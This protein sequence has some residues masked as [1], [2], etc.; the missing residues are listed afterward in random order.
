MS[1]TATG[2]GSWKSPITSES[3][4]K[5]TVGL[6][7]I[8]CEGTDRYWIE[9]R[10]SEEGRSVIVRCNAQGIVA[11]VTPPGFNAR[12]R[13]HEYGGGDYVVHQGTVF[14][15]NFSDQRLYRQEP[16]ATPEPITPEGTAPGA[17]ATGNLRYA[18]AVVD[19]GRN[20]LIC[21][22]E[23]HSDPQREAVNTLV[24]IGFDGEDGAGLLLVSGN[25]FY[26]SPRASPDGSRLAWLSWNHPHMPWD[27]TEL[28]VADFGSDGA[29]TN[30]RRVA[31]GNDESIF[32][33]EWSPDGVLYFV[34]DRS[35]WWNI[36]R[37]AGNGSIELV[38]GKDA[39]F[40]S[41]QWVFGMS[42]Y[43]FVS[44]TRIVCTYAE[45]GIWR[46]GLI[47]TASRVLEKIETPYSDISS[48]RVTGERTVFR[49]GSPNDVAAVV[50]LDLATRETTVLRRSNNV[51]VDPGYVSIPQPIEFPT[52]AGLTAH[53]FFYAPHNQD[54]TAPPN[55]LPLLLVK[56]HG[57]PTSAAVTTLGFNL[58][59]W[60]SRGIAVLDVNYGGSSG[61]GREYRRRLRGQWGI[62]DVDDCMNGA[63]HLVRDGKADPARLMI[64]GG[65][66]GG[67]TT[68]C[69]LTFRD[70]F[71]AGASHFGVSDAEALAKETHKFESRY[72][73]GLIG[74]YPERRDLYF[75]RSP[76][77]FTDQLSCPV[78]F[79][80]G[81]EDKIVPPSQ[82]E[83]MVEALRKKGIPVA[84]VAFAGEQHGFRRAANIRR[85]QDGE[86]YFY[87]RVFGFDLAEALEPVEIYNLDHPQPG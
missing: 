19:R 22:R 56:S 87:S 6:G 14:F 27:E 65:S 9:M 69:A 76:I 52:T 28:W 5:E 71:N 11:D 73:D 15:S 57:G 29:I 37:E 51:A 63:L 50:E 17:S 86:L 36:Y 32:Q 59:Y 60:T 47:D 48:L 49:G 43:A 25:D 53:A 70:I 58:Q 10:P 67:Y 4:V 66:A 23:D 1:V 81:L 3:I 74:P 2:Y 18:D 31:G 8:K 68:L 21:V 54:Y 34:S 45:R 78:I 55:E 79:F 35:G 61:Y 26:S 16:G 84:Y 24:C 72:L 46:L 40:G 44:A 82:A 80:Q 39:E 12:T 64:D 30:S 13:V 85:A 77:N 38:L 41:P 42:T 33:P 20:R 75:Q 7:Q 62:V 83:K